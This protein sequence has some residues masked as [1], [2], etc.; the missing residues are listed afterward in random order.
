MKNYILSEKQLSKVVEQIETQ[1]QTSGDKEGSYMAKQQLFT[2]A[3]MAYKMW[4]MMEDGQQLEDW[5][6]SKIA[7]SESSIIAVVK[8]FMY[9]DVKD[10]MKGMDTLD[11]DEL[12]IGK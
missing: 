9:D 4:E 10:K 6:E 1:P 3:T 12:I 5:M 8:S 2:I 7:Q 11:Y